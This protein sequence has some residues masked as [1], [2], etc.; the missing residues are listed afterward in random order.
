MSMLRLR[1]ILT[2]NVR[3]I[4]LEFIISFKVRSTNMKENRFYYLFCGNTKITHKKTLS[5]NLLNSVFNDNWKRLF[6][7]LLMALFLV[8]LGCKSKKEYVERGPFC[9][10]TISEEPSGHDNGINTRLS[11]DDW[12]RKYQDAWGKCYK[13]IPPVQIKTTN[14]FNPDADINEYGR[15]SA[16]HDQKVFE[17]MQQNYPELCEYLKIP[18]YI[19]YAVRQNE[20]VKNQILEQG[21]QENAELQSELDQQIERND[22]EVKRQK[23]EIDR[24]VRNYTPPRY[25]L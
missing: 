4:T 16:E 23:E 25:G 22:R 17:L 5:S 11:I 24:R 14:Y 18:E 15:L 6:A 8:L 7:Y 19:Q 13:S 12:Y 10:R 21:E 20:I 2:H 9:E 1:K 3:E